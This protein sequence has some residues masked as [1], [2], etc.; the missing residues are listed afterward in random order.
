MQLKKYEKEIGKKSEERLAKTM[1][2]SKNNS[3]FV[4][5]NEFISK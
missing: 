3:T 1:I 5:F 2:P 4:G